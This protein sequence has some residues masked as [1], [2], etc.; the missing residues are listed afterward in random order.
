MQFGSNKGALTS[1][2]PTNDQGLDLGRSFVRDEP[3][4]VAHVAHDVEMERDAVAAEDVSRHPILSSSS[5][6][7]S[8]RR[9]HDVLLTKRAISTQTRS[10]PWLAAIETLQREQDLTGLAPKGGFVAAQPV[11]GIC[12][13][14]G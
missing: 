6:I 3:F 2:I 9:A 4:H 5:A 11:E 12:R 1:D 13:Q 14:V 7:S 8:P 10:F